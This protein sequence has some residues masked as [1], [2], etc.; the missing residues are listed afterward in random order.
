L[1]WINPKWHLKNAPVYIKKRGDETNSNPDPINMTVST[2]EEKVAQ[3]QA[4]NN[5]LMSCV[6]SIEELLIA[7]ASGGGGDATP[8]STAAS[9]YYGRVPSGSVYLFYQM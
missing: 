5:E 9:W 3:L 6:T 7:A 8:K 1:V 4:D 2:L